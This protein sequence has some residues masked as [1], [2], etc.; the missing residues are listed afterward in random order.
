MDIGIFSPLRS[1]VAT[2]RL[3]AAL[4]A[5][6]EE[7]GVASIWLGEH[8][9]M[10][11]EYESKYPGTEDGVFRFPEGAGLLDMTAAIGYLAA[12]TKTIR[13][14]T[15]IRIL[16]QAN[17]VYTAKEYAT[18]D[19]LS[20]GRIDMGIG[21][22]WSWEEFEACAVP[23][24]QRGA[25]CDEY[26]EVMRT[27]WC[28]AHSQFSGDFYTLP[29]CRMYPKP[30][31]APMIPLTV[32]GHSTGALKRAARVGSG[33]YGINL[34]PLEVKGM[35]ERLDNYLE[36]QGRA[37]GSLRIVIGAVNDQIQ[38]ELV[39]EYA[40]AGVDE[41]LIPYLRQSEKWL[42]SYLDGLEKFT[43]AARKAG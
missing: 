14:G 42:D 18:L 7:R 12:H 27:L 39:H 5:G 11:D 28:D 29:K 13:L 19:F 41:L 36:A 21:V 22:G 1:P 24:E 38:P 17:P 35:I 8:V 32:G 31:Q 20:D 4:G 6:A 9:V 33:W 43:S 15:G 2:P 3:I 34:S 26:I 25:R 40:A 30:T 10:F 16:P 37:R 23:W